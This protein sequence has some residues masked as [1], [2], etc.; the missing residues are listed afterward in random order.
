MLSDDEVAGIALPTLVLL[1]AKSPIHRATQV[2]D[3]VHALLPDAQVEIVADSAH[4]L[5]ISDPELVSA[6]IT[7]FVDRMAS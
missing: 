3:R 5:T 2:R 7:A 1:G 6:R 4:A